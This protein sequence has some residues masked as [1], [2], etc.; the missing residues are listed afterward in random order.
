MELPDLKHILDDTPSHT[1]VSPAAVTRRVDGQRARIRRGA[2]AVTAVALVGTTAVALTLRQGPDAV[3]AS[4][5]TSASAPAPAVTTIATSAP[6]VAGPLETYSTCTVEAP[7]TWVALIEGAA[8]N[9]PTARPWIEQVGSRILWHG[10]AEHVVAE[11]AQTESI[12]VTDGRFVVFVD[13]AGNLRAWDSTS[14]G[15]T[16]EVVSAGD[17]SP[18][19]SLNTFQLADGVLWLTRTRAHS[20]DYKQSGNWTG[21]VETIDLAGDPEPQLVA[22]EKGLDAVEV[23]DG[24]IQ[25]MIHGGPFTLYEPDGTVREHPLPEDLRTT[26]VMS[27]SDHGLFLFGMDGDSSLYLPEADQQIPI[28]SPEGPAGTVD[29]PW[30][31]LQTGDE[32]VPQTMLNL[33]TQVRVDLPKRE[34]GPFTYTLRGGFLWVN[35]EA[36]LSSDPIALEDLPE[37]TCP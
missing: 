24:A 31:L 23:W 12:E 37:V 26:R 10:E 2:A 6:V 22:E 15:E 4:P 36:P 20:E 8:T 34:Y 32:E 16:P 28:N 5:G 1:T 25:V 17:F 27:Y 33:D 19:D 18:A 35:S 3:P 13:T 30:A 21:R 9:P 7:A 14:P 11:D 29:G